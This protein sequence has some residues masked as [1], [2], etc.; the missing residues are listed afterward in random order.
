MGTSSPNS[1]IFAFVGLSHMWIPA[2]FDGWIT[3]KL[4]TLKKG[5]DNGNID[6]PKTTVHV[7]CG[8]TIVIGLRLSFKL[9]Y[10]IT[11]R[12][13]I[14]LPSPQPHYIQCFAIITPFFLATLSVNCLVYWDFSKHSNLICSGGNTHLVR[15]YPRLMIYCCQFRAETLWIYD[16]TYLGRWIQWPTGGGSPARWR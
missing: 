10:W 1:E 12:A 7:S 5:S 9:F 6:Y 13:V 15:V 14:R 8:T 2:V 16:S 4:L 11:E 3:A